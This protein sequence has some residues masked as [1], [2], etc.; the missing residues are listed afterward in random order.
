[1]R[2]LRSSRASS[3][4]K[5]HLRKNQ[6]RHQRR[7]Q[8]AEQLDDDEALKEKAKAVTPIYSY[9][10]ITSPHEGDEFDARAHHE[11]WNDML[12]LQ[13]EGIYPASFVSIKVP[14]LMVHGTFDPHPGPLIK[15]SLAA[16]VRQLE[17][18]ELEQCGHYP[19]LEKA[20]AESFFS[21]VREWL[22]RHLAALG[23]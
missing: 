6:R 2:D 18:Q 20:T 10:A 1:M 3:T 13:A 15:S 23:K 12:R 4:Q 8:R 5:Y 21:L 7:A 19:W 17:Y 9:D 22:D 14:V 11:T 16:Y